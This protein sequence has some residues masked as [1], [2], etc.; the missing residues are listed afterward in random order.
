MEYHGHVKDEHVSLSDLSASR[1]SCEDDSRVILEFVEGEDLDSALQKLVHDVTLLSGL[2]DGETVYGKLISTQTKDSSLLLDIER[3]ELQ[4]LFHHIKISGRSRPTTR[5]NLRQVNWVEGEM[6]DVSDTTQNRYS[7]NSQPYQ[8]K[9]NFQATSQ[10]VSNQNV[11]VN[12]PLLENV[13]FNFDPSTQSAVQKEITDST[14][15]LVCKECYANVDSVSVFFEMAF[16]NIGPESFHAGVE[17]S[18]QSNVQFKI[19]NPSITSNTMVIQPE[20]QIA[21]F[22][23]AIGP[24]PVTL[25]VKSKL[26][27]ETTLGRA[28]QSGDFA[29]TGGLKLDASMRAGV[30]WSNSNGWSDINEFNSNIET[31]PMALVAQGLDTANFVNVKLVPQFTLSLFNRVPIYVQPSPSLG[32]DFGGNT[33]SCSAKDGYDMHAELNLGLG[34]GDIRLDQ[35]GPVIIGGFSSSFD[36]LSRS[37]VASTFLG[38]RICGDKTPNFCQ[39]CLSDL[40]FDRDALIDLFKQT[41]QSWEGGCDGVEDAASAYGLSS[42]EI[43]EIK[44]SDDLSVVLLVGV[45]AGVVVVITGVMM[46]VMVYRRSSTPSNNKKRKKKKR[47]KVQDSYIT[48]EQV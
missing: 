16:G 3:V 11:D 22:T 30:Q 20:T 32:Y 1:I 2:C 35:N 28:I 25:T 31:Y 45:A 12:Y 5:R 27:V 13:G 6:N 24:I 23:F 44:Q 47:A 14:G 21:S 29:A 4:D 42:A 43:Q 36:I 38:P 8:V 9:K 33:Q 40:K 15:S 10:D 18:V 37:S 46:G 17:G 19:Q 48:N 7:V 41:C 39:G 26:S 34:V